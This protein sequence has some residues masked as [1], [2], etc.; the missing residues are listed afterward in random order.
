MALR[1]KRAFALPLSGPFCRLRLH[2]WPKWRFFD[3]CS[4]PFWRFVTRDGGSGLTST[5][6]R[7]FP[8]LNTYHARF[9]RNW[10]LKFCQKRLWRQKPPKSLASARNMRCKGPKLQNFFLRSRS[11]LTGVKRRNRRKIPRLSSREFSRGIF[12]HAR[13]GKIFAA[14][15]WHHAPRPRGIA[16]QR[17]LRECQ[18][19]TQM[20]QKWQ[21]WP[22][23]KNWEFWKF[24]KFKFLKF[25]FQNFQFWWKWPKRVK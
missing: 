15:R 20:C 25:L 6:P 17:R 24:S 8:R 5:K 12:A 16:D 11:Y 21:F 2:F 13:E 7:D 3:L 14:R 1:A 23:L 22:K 19:L 4:C 10:L 18:F 9:F